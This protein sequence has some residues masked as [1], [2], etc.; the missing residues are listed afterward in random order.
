M[1]IFLYRAGGLFFFVLDCAASLDN[2]KSRHAFCCVYYTPTTIIQRYPCVYNV[3]RFSCQVSTLV[4]SSFRPFVAFVFDI[5][6]FLFNLLS[7]KKMHFYVDQTLKNVHSK[8]EYHIFVRVYTFQQ[9]LKKSHEVKYLSAFSKDA[10]L[11]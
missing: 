9:A 11:L 7:K 4:S 3:V 10:N 8:R 2:L 6:Y 5:L 1:S